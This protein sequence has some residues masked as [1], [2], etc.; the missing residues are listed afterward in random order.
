MFLVGDTY[1]PI[2]K[3]VFT[4]LA[5]FATNAMNELPI[6]LD[7]IAEIYIPQMMILIFILI[8]ILYKQ[9]ELMSIYNVI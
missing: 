9:K 1:L 7:N 4:T 3:L 6:M 5:P 8:F 2:L